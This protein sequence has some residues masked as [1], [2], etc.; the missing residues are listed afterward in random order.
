M[1]YI[2]IFVLLLYFVVRKKNDKKT[3]YL[4]ICLMSL[5]MGLRYRCG[6][7][8]QWYTDEFSSFPL[9]GEL[10]KYNFHEAYFY[11]GWIIVNSFAKTLFGEFFVVQLIES[12]FVNLC[13][14]RFFYKYS[15]RPMLCLFLYYCLFFLYFNTEIM[16]QA[17]SCAFF[18]ISVDYL[19][20]NRLIKYYV[21]CI[22]A[23]AF[24]PSAFFLFLMPIFYYLMSGLNPKK[25]LVVFIL[26]LVI[27]IS[28]S[29][30]NQ[31]LMAL[32]FTDFL[33]YKADAYIE[34]DSYS[35]LYLLRKV[36]P[37]ILIISVLLIKSNTVKNELKRIKEGKVGKKKHQSSIWRRGSIEID[38]VP[39]EIRYYILIPLFA[40]Y[41]LIN[42]FITTLSGILVSRIAVF[43]AG[44]VV[45]MLAEAIQKVSMNKKFFTTCCINVALCFLT[46]NE[47]RY[48][49]NNL[50]DTNYSY[51]KLWYPYHSVLLMEDEPGRAAAFYSS[52]AGD[53]L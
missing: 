48:Y 8:T 16:R 22:F 11:P 42:L 40:L 21:C 49:S 5:F 43:L 6:G 3:Y 30:S 45:I 12:F 31:L 33:Q 17:F 36:L 35:A 29:N 50:H 4:T 26:L 52:M 20:T 23:F 7:D 38:E 13:F 27:N 14:G 47:I 25:I 39:L 19:V 37:Y 51:Y 18:L 28:F 10:S 53:H 24:H 15:Q 2:F 44:V 41:I 34:Q 32:M 9:L 46:Y 1:E